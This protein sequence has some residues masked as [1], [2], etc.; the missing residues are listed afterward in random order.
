MN[1]LQSKSLELRLALRLGAVFLVATILIAIAFFFYLGDRITNSLTRQVL[2]AHADDLAF[3][4]DDDRPIMSADQLV[5]AGV[6]EA[7]TAYVIRDQEGN[8]LAS[9]DLG[10]EAAVSNV[11]WTRGRAQYFT[12]DESDSQAQAYTG[13]ATRESSRRGTVTVIV[14]EPY[15]PE[16]AILEEML[17]EF[18]ETVVWI[19]PI[20]VLVTLGVGIAA[21]RG[22]LKPLIKTAAQSA[23]IRPE[24]LSVRLDTAELPTEIAPMV[25]AFNQALDRVEEGFEIQRRFT[26]NAAHELRT[27]L[28]VISGALENLGS[29]ADTRALRN[30]VERMT[31]LVNQLLQ[32]A[33]LDSGILDRSELID[34]KSCATNVV[35]YMAPLAIDRQRSL[36]L[37]GTDSPVF[38]QGNHQAVEDALRNLIEN[39]INHTPIDTE[40]KVNVSDDYVIEVSDQ[41]PGID[42]DLGAQIFERFSRAPSNRAPGTG[43][44]LAIVMEVVKLHE[45]KIEYINKSEGGACFRM[46]FGQSSLLATQA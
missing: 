15:N 40:V 16:N 8:S 39:A 20:F 17:E 44:G 34:L 5:E 13:L 21:I 36:A 37:T 27:P 24:S 19:I 42:K 23:N 14:A 46:I 30:D 18:A 33:R 6:I 28:T 4:I 22:G 11:N 41:G 35:N 38:I 9:S 26:A 32:V 2:F 29:E 3:S 45:G 12:L 25:A 10:F 43:L 31:R 1:I 7:T